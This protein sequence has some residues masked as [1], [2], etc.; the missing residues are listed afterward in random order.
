MKLKIETQEQV[1]QEMLIKADE[2]LF[3]SERQMFRVWWD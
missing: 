3:D 1:E 2:I